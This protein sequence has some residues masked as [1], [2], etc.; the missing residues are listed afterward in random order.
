LL[1]DGI[2]LRGSRHSLLRDQARAIRDL[3]EAQRLYRAGG[4]TN[5]AESLLLDIAISYRRMGDFD[6]A[7]DYLRQNEAYARAIGDY[8]Q[9]F[10][11]LL[12]QGYLAE[13]KGD[14][15]TA[16]ALYREVLGMAQ[17]RASD[18]DVASVH[19]AMAWPYILRKEYRRALLIVDAARSQFQDLGDRANED[20]L[21]LRSGQAHA[22]LGDH[23]R[24]LAEYAQ[25]AIAL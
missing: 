6:K 3:I 23:S 9:L 18:Y 17:D 24:A 7:S 15:D 21:A 10:A 22:G 12:Q 13:D 5:D 19:L 2:S 1:A 25:A 20:M 16:L 14:V 8:Y 11:N 4:Y